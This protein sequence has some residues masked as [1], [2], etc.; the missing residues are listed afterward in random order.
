MSDPTLKLRIHLGDHAHL[1]R[2]CDTVGELILNAAKEAGVMPADAELVAAKWGRSV[3][4]WRE[5]GGEWSRWRPKLSDRDRG[6]LEAVRESEPTG[7]VRSL[8]LII[9]TL[10]EGAK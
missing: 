9:D 5:T 7:L 10:T 4:E 2:S 3:E 6:F 8:L 1:G